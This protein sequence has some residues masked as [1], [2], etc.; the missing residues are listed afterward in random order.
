[1][2]TKI[3]GGLRKSIYETR[4]DVLAEQ[5]SALEEK[6]EE[7][8]CM[9]EPSELQ[10]IADEI[11]IVANGWDTKNKKGCATRAR[12]WARRLRELRR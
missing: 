3:P 12:D 2:E 1:M 9:Q 7:I 10:V 4:I 5:V 11:E 6:L 8:L